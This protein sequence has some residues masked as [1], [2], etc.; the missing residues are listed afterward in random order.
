[1]TTR[2]LLFSYQIRFTALTGDSG[3]ELARAVFVVVLGC[4]LVAWVCCVGFVAVIVAINSIVSFAAEKRKLPNTFTSMKQIA[5]KLCV[6]AKSGNAVARAAVRRAILQADPLVKFE[7][8]NNPNDVISFWINTS[9]L[10]S[11]V[12]SLDGVRDAIFS[13]PE[14]TY[15]REIKPRS[16]LSAS[17]SY[18][19][20][21]LA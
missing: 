19:I 1:V 11:Q 2:V 3:C 4:C 15:Y 14:C 13:I 16:F 7:E 10:P 5:Y 12:R 6:S 17:F 9:L 8:S 20:R 18:L 21:L